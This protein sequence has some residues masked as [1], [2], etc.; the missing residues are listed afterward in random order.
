MDKRILELDKYQDYEYKGI[1]N[2]AIGKP[3]LIK[4]SLDKPI[5][6]YEYFNL[7]EERLIDLM[8]EHRDGEEIKVQLTT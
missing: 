4:S 1:K 5:T 3:K 7:V 2:I 6:P 8:K